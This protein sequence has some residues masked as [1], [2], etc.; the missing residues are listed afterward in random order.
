[1]RVFR[2]EKII[3]PTK[4]SEGGSL[5]TRRGLIKLAPLVLLGACDI[6]P[7]GKMETFLRKVQRFNDGVQATAFDPNKLSPEYPDSD[8]TPLKDFRVNTDSPH[9]LDLS[10]IDAKNWSLNVGGLVAKPGRYTIEQIKAL[11]KRVQ[12]TKHVCV[13]GWSMNPKWGGARLVDFL[14]MIGAEPRGKY[15]HVTSADGY[16]T[17]YDIESAR[18][19]QSLLCYEAY[20]A[21]LNMDHG[22]PLRIVMPTKLGYKS[23]KWIVSLWVTD[24]RPS[25]YWEDEGYDWFAGI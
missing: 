17:S 19:T 15:V 24:Q 5:L 21:P 12:N 8:L 2:N 10:M 22:A 23:A 7:Q 20:N 4:D 9:P 16:Y 6:S 3:L 1:M 14:T 25:G 11:P 18:H 13:E